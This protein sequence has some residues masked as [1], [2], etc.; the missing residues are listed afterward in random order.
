MKDSKWLLR[1]RRFGNRQGTRSRVSN[2]GKQI[3]SDCNKTGN[4]TNAHIALREIIDGS[5]VIDIF[6]AS[7]KPK[8]QEASL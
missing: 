6:V 3:R 5:S 4:Q 2:Y 8:D 1:I 7:L